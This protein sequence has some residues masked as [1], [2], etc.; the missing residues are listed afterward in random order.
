MLS[1]FRV[2]FKREGLSWF[3]KA[4]RCDGRASAGWR[5]KHGNPDVFMQGG[6]DIPVPWTI[7]RSLSSAGCPVPPGTSVPALLHGLRALPFSHVHFTRGVRGTPGAAPDPSQGL[8]WWEKS[9][10]SSS[11]EEFQQP[12][13]PL[14]AEFTGKI[15]LQ[16]SGR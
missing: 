6:F 9:T 10:P 8:K 3:R 5:R 14:P 4:R 16:F 1:F 15:P 7:P 13:D 11:N 12:L 2:Y